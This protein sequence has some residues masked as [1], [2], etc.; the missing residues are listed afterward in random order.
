MKT[1]LT[2]ALLLA[3]SAAYPAQAACTQAELAGTWTAETLSLATGGR[4]IWITCTLAINAVGGFTANTSACLNS[5]GQRSDARGTLKVFDAP[6]CAFA[7]NVNLVGFKSN[8][9]VRNL[10]LAQDH[11][12]A[13]GVGGGGN[14]YGSAFSFNLVKVK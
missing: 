1:V 11:S 14:Q 9:Y 12:V 3:A 5:N 8:L 6:N 4:L 7:G 2:A 13:S 10:T